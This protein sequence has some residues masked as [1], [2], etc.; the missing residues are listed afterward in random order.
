M[1]T[2]IVHNM[3][4]TIMADRIKYEMLH[5]ILNNLMF[6]TDEL[7]KCKYILMFSNFTK[8]IGM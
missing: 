8:K 1:K 5:K 6:S 2:F 3:D 4:I 7:S